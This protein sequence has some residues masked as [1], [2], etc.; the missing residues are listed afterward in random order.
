MS[1]TIILLA[2]AASGA[3]AAQPAYAQCGGKGFT[4]GTTCVSG[5]TCTFSNAYYS[6]CIPSSSGATTVAPVKSSSTSQA[7]AP[8]STSN[9]GGGGSGNVLKAS[10][11]E[12][13]AGDSF[14]S[15][16]CQTATT[17]CG[18]YTTGFNAAASQN[19]FGVGP[20]AGAGPDC[21]LCY[22]LT[23]ETDSSGKAV[24]NAGNSIVV[25]ITNLCPGI[26]G[27][28]VNFDTCK[29]SGASAALFGNSGVGLGLGTAVQV[30]CSQ[31]AS[32]VGTHVT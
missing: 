10:F 12:Y 32:Q 26:Y 16:N 31:Y 6:Q 30:P 14:G 25:E 9:N 13:G 3:F 5:Y 7:A 2:S 11:T 22:R 19:L 18:Y 21:G 17:A 15:P 28:N 29:D 8:T 24:S 27:A 23:I 4:G 1:T 20:G